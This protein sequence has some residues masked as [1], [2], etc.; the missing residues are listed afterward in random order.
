MKISPTLVQNSLKMEIELFPQ[1][2]P[3][4]PRPRLHTGMPPRPTE[5]AQT[6]LDNKSKNNGSQCSHPNRLSPDPTKWSNTQT[7]RRQ[8][9]LPTKCL[10]V[11]DHSM[12]LMLKRL[13]KILCFVHQISE[14]CF[15]C[16]PLFRNSLWNERCLKGICM[17]KG[18]CGYFVV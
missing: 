6:D 5:K 16:I 18:M 8:L 1:C 7:I 4:Q 10:A 2:T 9:L 14:E 15:I 13:I 12:G 11:L 3:Q 17:Q